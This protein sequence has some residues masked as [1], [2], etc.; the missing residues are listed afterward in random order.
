M[1]YNYVECRGSSFKRNTEMGKEVVLAK[2][3][4]EV[5]MGKPLAVAKVTRVGTSTS[6]LGGRRKL[7]E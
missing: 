6:T 5:N 2:K 7:Q 3:L 1:S 4:V